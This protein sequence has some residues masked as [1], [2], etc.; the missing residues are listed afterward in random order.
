MC[1]QASLDQLAAA[2][3]HMKEGACWQRKG[4]GVG[5]RL[6]LSHLCLP[7]SSPCLRSAPMPPVGAHAVE[8]RTQVPRMRCAESLRPQLGR[9]NYPGGQRCPVPQNQ[10]QLPG[11]HVQMRVR[12]SVL[13]RYE[14][15]LTASLWGAR[16]LPPVPVSW[17]GV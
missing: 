5:G 8:P 13:D 17:G 10:S 6:L 16:D 1:T 9:A 14:W 15:R 7:L 4:L 11:S 12:K 3:K 2:S